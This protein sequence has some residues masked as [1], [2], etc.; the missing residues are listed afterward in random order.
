MV[1]AVGETLVEPFAPKVPP[2]LSIETLVAS[3][4]VHESVELFPL[5]MDEGVAVKLETVGAAGAVT[6]TVTVPV[7]VPPGP[8]AVRV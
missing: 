8:V 2:P 5:V 7:F 1:V 4:V 3:V 6:V